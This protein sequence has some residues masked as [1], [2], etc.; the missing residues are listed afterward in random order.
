MPAPAFR[1]Y[2]LG[3]VTVGTICG[4]VIG[5][6][7]L[8]S[9]NF[10]ALGDDDRA[11]KCL[12]LGVGGTV[13]LCGASLALPE[14]VPIPNSVFHWIQIGI[15]VPYVKHAQGTMVEAHKILGGPFYSKWRAAAV[16]LMCAVAIVAT[17]VG[18]YLVG[19][20]DD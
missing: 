14:D 9:K 6:L 8:A 3:A 1:L 12:W 16:G 17:I 13:L 15:V 20:L 11:R 4:S 19:I 10:S 5:G 2:S 18:A 7:P